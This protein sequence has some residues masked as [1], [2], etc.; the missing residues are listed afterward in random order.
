M[1]KKSLLAL[2]IVGAFSFATAQNANAWVVHRRAP[3]RRAVARTVLPPYPLARRVIAGPVYRR[4]IVAAPTVVVTPGY[5]TY[6]GG[7]YYVW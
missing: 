1:L 6:Y 7:G 5:S 4:P 2:A 3:V